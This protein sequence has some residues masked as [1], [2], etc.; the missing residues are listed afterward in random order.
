MFA[1]ISRV[2]HQI[3]R[4]IT[5]IG[6]FPPILLNTVLAFDCTVDNYGN[7]TQLIV[8]LFTDKIPSL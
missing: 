7:C 3:H 5:P 2:E 6:S 1:L 8:A 4:I